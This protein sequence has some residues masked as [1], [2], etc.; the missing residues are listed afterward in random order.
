M[1]TPLTK[2]LTLIL[3]LV[4]L[5]GILLHPARTAR[6]GAPAKLAMN[7][8]L[9]G[10]TSAFGK[11]L[12][13]WQELYWRWYY[14]GTTIPSDSNGNAAVGNVVLMPIPPTPGDGTPGHQDVTMNAGQAWIMPLWGL[15]GTSYSDGTSPDPFVDT[16][17]FRTLDLTLEVD[18]KTVVSSANQM[19]YFS[20]I[21]F[22]PPLPLDFPPI[23]AGIWIQDVGIMHTPMTVGTHTMKLD[24]KNTI[25]VPPNFGGGFAE[26]HNTWTIEV[27]AHK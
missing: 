10:N 11:S 17:I 4:A 14:G 5:A 25:P 21:A 12:G 19:N 7:S 16:E 18:G 15:I 1:K 20:Q 3:T 8:I 6:A 23:V 26:F 24:V 22:D 9:P 2:Q 27:R 13:E